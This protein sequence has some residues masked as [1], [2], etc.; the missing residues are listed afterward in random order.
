MYSV[1]LT[2]T[3]EAQIVYGREFQYKVYD[4]GPYSK[5]SDVWAMGHNVL[6]GAV[7]DPVMSPVSSALSLT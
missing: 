4:A 2:S 5:G 3:I 1:R 7:C 6:I